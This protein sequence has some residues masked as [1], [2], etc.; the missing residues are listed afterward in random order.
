MRTITVVPLRL[1]KKELRQRSSELN[2][3]MCEWDPIGVMDDPDWPRDEYDCLVS[4]VLSLL[5]SGATVEEV[6][7][8]LR[9]EVTDHIGLSPDKYDFL[10]VARRF[11]NWFDHAW[12]EIAAPV[13]I[14]VPLLNEGVDVWRP[15]QARPLRRD[16]FR[17]VGVDGDVRDEVWQFPAGA[18]VKC[19]R[20]RFEN[21]TIGLTAIERVECA[22]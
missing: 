5:Q 1:T 20:R 18:V 17:I 6:A 19:A 4:P 3:L 7:T 21:G 16:V 12:R 11:R 13:T 2:E 10:A 22:G 9:K 14:F 15:V 8:H